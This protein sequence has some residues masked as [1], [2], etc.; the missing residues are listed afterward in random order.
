MAPTVECHV[1]PFKYHGGSA[2]QQPGMTQHC[3][4]GCWVIP[5][6]EGL[7]LL[8]HALQH[9]LMCYC[10]IQGL[11]QEHLQATHI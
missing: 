8:L 7:E 11:V 3:I 6:D 9:L 2:D 5:G 4:R 1:V 10:H